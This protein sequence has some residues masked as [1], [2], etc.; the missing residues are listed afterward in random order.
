MQP[1]AGLTQLGEE[2]NQCS[3]RSRAVLLLGAVGRCGT[4]VVAHRLEH[5]YGVGG[6]LP[7][8]YN[9]ARW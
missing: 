1:R 6:I 3:A 2:G 7:A 9:V 5:E 8:R 4:E